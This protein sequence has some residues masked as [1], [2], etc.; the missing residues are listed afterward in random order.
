MCGEGG[1]GGAGQPGLGQALFCFGVFNLF[2]V[3]APPV[4]RYRPRVAVP[5]DDR[6]A[7]ACDDCDYLATS[8]ANLLRHRLVHTGDRPFTCAYVVLKVFSATC[9]GSPTRTPP[10][11]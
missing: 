7:F 3:V 8:A 9:S 5:A 10:L 1:G 6:P 4:R 2:S 11:K